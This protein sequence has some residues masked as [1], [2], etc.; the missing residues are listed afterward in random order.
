MK[1]RLKLEAVSKVTDSRMEY[2]KTIVM[3]IHGNISI[4]DMEAYGFSSNN[5]LPLIKTYW[6]D[7]FLWCHK[8]PF[9]K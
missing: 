7:G 4:S 1:C 3:Q 2:H 8:K 5:G 6:K 9:S